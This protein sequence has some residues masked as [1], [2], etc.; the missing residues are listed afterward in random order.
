MALR[1]QLQMQITEST[2]YE[3]LKG[4]ILHYESITTRWGATNVLQMPTMATG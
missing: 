4:K 3:Q 2:T 1:T